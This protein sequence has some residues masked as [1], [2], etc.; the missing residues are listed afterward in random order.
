ME[1]FKLP[2]SWS[3]ITIEQFNELK[4]LDNNLNYYDRQLHI[5]SILVDRLPD[6]D[7][8][9]DVDVDSITSSFNELKWLSIEPSTNKIDYYKEYKSIDFSK[10]TFGEFLDLEYYFI[11]WYSNLDK[12]SAVVFRLYKKDEWNNIVLQEYGSYDIE[13][14]AD[15]FLNESINNFYWILKVYLDWKDNTLSIY[16]N[17]FEPVI[18]DEDED[19]IPDEDDIEQ[20]RLESINNKWGWEQVLHQ[21]SNGDI[22]KYDSITK[23]PLILILNQMSFR[24]EL[25]L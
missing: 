7:Y 8:W 11:D 25:K 21:F 1:E 10:I 15:V 5:L 23:L 6:D 24:K 2:N 14:R 12:I 17:L 19:Y 3:E 13:E 4:Q 16:Q 18:T 20:E 22:T 9:E